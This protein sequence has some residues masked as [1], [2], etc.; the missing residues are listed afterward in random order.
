MK[1]N[2]R[3]QIVGHL[4]P[5]GFLGLFSGF[6]ETLD[7]FRQPPAFDAPLIT[8]TFEFLLDRVLPLFGFAQLA[9]N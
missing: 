8:R 4:N 9:L 5:S 1:A 2:F 3:L 6:A 7:F